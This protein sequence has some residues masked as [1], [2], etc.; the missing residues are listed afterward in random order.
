MVVQLLGVMCNAPALPRD[1]AEYGCLVVVMTP[2]LF[3][4]V[5]EFKQR[6]ADYAASVR[7]ARPVAGSQA[8][9]MPFDRS[10]AERRRRLAE[11]SIEVPDAVHEKLAGIAGM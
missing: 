6:V 5:A 7:A 11:D 3:M 1:I 8:V 2:G 9:R 10:A 4:P